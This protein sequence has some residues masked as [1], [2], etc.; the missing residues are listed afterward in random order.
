M[1]IESKTAKNGKVKIYAD[2]EEAF[3]VP[4][5]IWYSSRFHDGDEV[6]EDELFE[7]KSLSDSFSAYESALRMLSLRAHSEYEL[8]MKLKHKFSQDA[9]VAALRRLK[10]AGL[11]NDRE[12]ALRFAEE[13][14][15][16]KGYSPKRILVELKYRG[17]SEEDAQ[18]AINALD[19]D[20]KIGII[21]IL[22]KCPLTENS[23]QKEKNRV[24]RR[25]LNLG[26]SYADI[27]KY[28]N[29]DWN[30]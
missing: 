11:T 13:L 27:S 28:I 24:I 26:Y 30:E 7:L 17:I 12:F 2:G 29:T 8:Y 5:E 23:T 25:L 9:A 15:T 14:Y 3:T 22:E 20:E 4:A 1:K 16:R 10:A 19:I 18:N 6:S 21:K